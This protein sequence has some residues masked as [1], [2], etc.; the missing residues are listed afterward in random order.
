MILGAALNPEGSAADLASQARLAEAAGL[1]FLAVGYPEREVRLDPMSVAAAL[2]TVT[3]RIGLCPVVPTAGRQPFNI[4][5]AFATLDHL[6]RGRAGWFV[7]EPAADARSREV[8]DVAFQLWDSWED[9]ALVLDKPNAVFTDPRK[10]HRINH[11]GAHFTV[12]GPLNA[13][14]PLQGRPPVFVR[15]GGAEAADV[16]IIAGLD[17][18]R[19]PA[20]RVL[21]ELA[22]EGDAAGLADR[23]DAGLASG[24]CDGFLLV[25]DIAGT[26]RALA[27]ELRRRGLMGGQE[28]GGM[29]RE[30]LGL[31]R[32]ASRYAARPLHV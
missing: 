3:R 1:D 22:M 21:L 6:S 4:A 24:A 26:L 16:V 2:I 13:P 18:G 12:E 14:R 10:V 17:T 29:L 32:P 28:A 23:M 5:R 7:S 19:P 30:R 9:D 11:A 8:L 15:A 20:P 25:G 31:P 27:L